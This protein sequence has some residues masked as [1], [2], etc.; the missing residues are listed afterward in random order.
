LRDIFIGHHRPTGKEFDELWKNSTIVVDTSAILNLY[1][2]SIDARKD[3]LNALHAINGRLWM[4]HQIAKEFYDNRLERIREQR[5][6]GTNISKSLETLTKQATAELQKRA[7]NP[8]LD[9]RA[10][11]NK[12]DQFVSELNKE[13]N[14]QHEAGLQRYGITFQDDPILEDLG[15]MYSGRTGKPYGQ[16]KLDE[17]KE[18]ARE[19]YSEKI[20]PGY[21]D[22]K[23][24]TNDRA[25]GDFIV[26]RQILDYARTS[27]T[28]ILFVTDDNKEDWWW[29]F[30][31]Q[32]LGP[33][34]ELRDEFHAETG[35]IFYAYTPENFLSNLQKLNMIDISS[36]VVDEVRSTSEHSAQEQNERDYLGKLE[37]LRLKRRN[38]KNLY[39]QAEEILRDQMSRSDL[40]R[41]QV[42]QL[43][44]RKD[45]LAAEIAEGDQ[46]EEAAI[47]QLHRYDESLTPTERR[48]LHERVDLIRRFRESRSA[49]M[50]ALEH[51]LN[52]TKASHFN[53]LREADESRRKIERI[54]ASM[55]EIRLS[56]LGEIAITL[57]KDDV[58]Q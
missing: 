52:A 7:R 37:S 18:V 55:N 47:E 20:P 23:E 44:H 40:L 3:F 58:S 36:E 17:L 8:F 35:Q 43:E 34:P 24:K 56:D 51:E 10:L 54:K 11:K 53:Y 5:E 45:R 28:N 32:T 14:Q 13:I 48:Y 46:E 38:A 39:F 15:S 33:R 27:S 21:K 57:D 26:W 25:Y 22:M 9:T 16:D 29:R 42:I 30:E 4:P 49:E 19:R 31:G 12:I 1:R 50:A 2:Y 6:T 41:K